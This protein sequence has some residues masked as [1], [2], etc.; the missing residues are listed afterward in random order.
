MI[1]S[2]CH[3]VLGL[4]FAVTVCPTEARS[5]SPQQLQLPNDN[6][7]KVLWQT[8]HL[9]N[10]ASRLDWAWI[11]GVLVRNRTTPIS[12][13]AVGGILI[14]SIYSMIYGDDHRN[15]SDFS[16][17]L[18]Y[19]N[20]GSKFPFNVT[21]KVRS[22]N[23]PAPLNLDASRLGTALSILGNHYDSYWDLTQLHEWDFDIGVVE[24]KVYPAQKSLNIIASGSISHLSP[25]ADE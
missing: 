14:Q 7:T 2:I 4:L 12:G 11:E 1:R 16:W 24:S 6:S 9:P 3:F 17:T 21:L 13:Q 25:L 18:A 8:S 22:Y 5:G 15:I 20:R 23:L 19:P 10:S